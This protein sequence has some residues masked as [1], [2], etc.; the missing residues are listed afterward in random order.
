M[1]SEKAKLLS[2]VIKDIN[3]KS[4]VSGFAF[5]CFRQDT[6]INVEVLDAGS[7]FI[8]SDGSH[9]IPCRFS[10]KALFWFKMNNSNM[11]L[12]ELEGRHLVI[13]E[14]SVGSTLPDQQALKVYLEVY[15]FILLSIEEAKTLSSPTK[16]VKD[17]LKEPKL[18]HSLEALRLLN[19]RHA[20]SSKSIELPNLEE[21]LGKKSSKGSKKKLKSFISDLKTPEDYGKHKQGKNKIIEPEEMQ[22]IEREISKD[23]AIIFEQDER[24]KGKIA[25][26]SEGNLEADT[27]LSKV[28]SLIKDK[29]IVEMLKDHGTFHRRRIAAKSP[30][31][32]GPIPTNLEEIVKI[33]KEDHKERKRKSLEDKN[34]SKRSEKKRAIEVNNKKVA[35]KVKKE[36]RSPKP[37]KTKS[38][39]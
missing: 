31:K 4:V 20:I 36:T 8:V 29:S 27:M 11:D 16:E 5:Q 17:I 26:G 10:K 13:S 14:Y 28:Q 30:V 19:L 35:A 24:F 15:S 23:V 34:S 3:A 2:A 33:I 1:I 21:I 37:N 32:R 39:K 7:N 22:S 9:Y 18:K 38:H 12:N 6:P 25:A